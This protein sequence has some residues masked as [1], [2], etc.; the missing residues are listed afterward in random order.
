MTLKALTLIKLLYSQ[1]AT[2]KNS[3][4]ALPPSL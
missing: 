4:R 1:V 3:G 2:E